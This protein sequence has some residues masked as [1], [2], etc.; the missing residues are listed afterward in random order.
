MCAIIPGSIFLSFFFLWYRGLN[1]GRR[2][3]VTP[4]VHFCDEFFQGRVL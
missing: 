2:S 3:L 4:P 1:S